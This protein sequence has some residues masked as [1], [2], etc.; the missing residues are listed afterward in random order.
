MK[1]TAVGLAAGAR[2]LEERYRHYKKGPLSK[3]LGD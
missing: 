2:N 3:T 1:N